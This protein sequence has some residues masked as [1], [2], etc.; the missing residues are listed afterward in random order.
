[1]KKEG[2]EERIRMK[3]RQQWNTIQK[4]SVKERGIK[5]RW[6]GMLTEDFSR[7]KERERER[8]EVK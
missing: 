3:A 2:I 7:E 5:D 6:Y 4:L 8:D 1:M